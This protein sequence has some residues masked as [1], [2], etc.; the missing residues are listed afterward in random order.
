VKLSVHSQDESA[1]NIDLEVDA[2]LFPRE[3][4]SNSF[5]IMMTIEMV[6]P[7]F[8]EIKV[9][10]FGSFEFG[11]NVNEEERDLLIN[12]NAPA[13]MF[14]Y[15]RSFISTL[16]ANCGGSVPISIIPPHFFSGSLEQINLP[17]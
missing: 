5:R 4:G 14:P 6:V 2:K 8:W 17:E 15:F 13:I 12:V 11:E 7:D 16:T 1:R 9:A 3:P 10:G